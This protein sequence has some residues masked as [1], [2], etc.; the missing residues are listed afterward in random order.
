MCIRD[1]QLQ[2][3]HMLSKA[4]FWKAHTYIRVCSIIEEDDDSY[5]GTAARYKHLHQR[6]IRDTRIEA[7]IQVFVLAW[8]APQ[9]LQRVQRE[10][11][12]AHLTTS[13]SGSPLERLA[14]CPT[15]IGLLG[16]LVHDLVIENSDLTAVSMLPLLPIPPLEAHS[17]HGRRASSVEEEE[18]IQMLARITSGIGPAVLVLSLIHISEPTRP[19]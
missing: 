19:Y 6:V 13:G 14:S 4:S 15:G 8:D 7:R 16:D 9:L 10:A 2:L 1:R 12:L 5:E 18:Y 17:S 3:A 11:K